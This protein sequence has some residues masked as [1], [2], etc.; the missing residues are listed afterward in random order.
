MIRRALID[1]GIVEPAVHRLDVDPERILSE[2]TTLVNIDE[3]YRR[4]QE[5]QAWVGWTEESARR[6][7]A[8]AEL[9]APHLTA[10][11]DDFYDEIGHHPNA[12]KVITG[13]QPQ[14][15]R[16][17]GLLIQWL[18]ELLG[19]RYDRDYVARR[20]QVGRRHV[21]IGLEQVYTNVALSRLRLG[22][23]RTL[24]ND[25][26]GGPKELQQ[27]VCS[28]NKLLDLDL[29]IIGDAYQAEY[30]AR[31]QRSERLAAIGLVA[32]GVAHELRNPLNVVKTSVYYLLNARNPSPEKKT[33]HLQ[34]IEKHVVL[35]DGVITALSNFAKLP[36]PNRVPFAVEPCIRSVLDINPL[37]DN[38][39]LTIDCS[40]SL[41]PAL[42]DFDQIHIVFANL[43][44]NAR[45]A[46][47]EGGRL[48]ITARASDSGVEVIIADTGVGIS[49][50]QFSRVME[51]LY[52]TKARGLGLGLPIARA[53]LEKNGGSLRVASEPGQGSTFT[54]FLQTH[55]KQ[56][57]DREGA[58]VQP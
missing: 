56:S 46:M 39:Q 58:K 30:A 40:P 7:A 24:Q 14:I 2:R 55:V 27:T 28:L 47:S 41:P 43:V 35:A 20:W 29:A 12:R 9:L 25:W 45:E 34:R 37:T 21:E 11:I 32:G 50:E 17:K 26:R 31:L 16:L 22:L 54:V 42:A 49:A 33:E 13:E 36:V 6:V 18:R 4:Y 38:I 51:P 53:I 57:R 52:S 44:R 48:S 5:L 10:L 15:N 1:P 3:V 23:M 19:G 8:T